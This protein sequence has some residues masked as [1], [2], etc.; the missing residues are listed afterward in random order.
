M[1]C[2]KVPKFFAGYPLVA[3]HILGNIHSESQSTA[4]LIFQRGSEFFHPIGFTLALLCHD[5]P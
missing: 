5:M 2:G 1:V 3:M 4:A